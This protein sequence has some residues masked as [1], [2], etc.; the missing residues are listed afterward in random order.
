MET[1]KNDLIPY[2][3]GAFLPP[4][5]PCSP[6]PLPITW[7]DCNSLNQH[8]YEVVC[9]FYSSKYTCSEYS[10]MNSITCAHHQLFPW[11]TF[12]EVNLVNQR[13]HLFKVFHTHCQITLQKVCI[14]F[15]L[16][17]H[18]RTNFLSISDA[19]MLLELQI[20]QGDM[21]FCFHFWLTL[22]LTTSLQL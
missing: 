4:P 3:F 8:P 12:L 21:A 11:D 2:P 22:L 1:F 9:T 14:K 16:P 7:I 6:L 15:S 20:W 13:W 18:A 5:H 19:V 17:F 10:C